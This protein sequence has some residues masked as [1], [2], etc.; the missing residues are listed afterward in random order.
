MTRITPVVLSG[1]A[2]TR[3]WPLSREQFPKQLL[4]LASVRSMI[5]DTVLR[6]TDTVRFGS[7]IVVTNEETRF[8]VAEQLREIGFEQ[9]SV[10][11]EPV[12]RNTAPAVAAAALLALEADPNAIILV[13]PS[14]HVLANLPAFLALVDKTAAAARDGYLVTFSIV[15][16]RP[17]TGYGYIR[18]GAA[19]NSHPD[20]HAVAAF[21]EKPDAERAA[22]FLAEG[23]YFWNSGMFLFSAAIFIDELG[24]HAPEVLQAVRAAVTGKTVDHDFVRLEAEAFKTCPGIS[25]DYA[26]MEKTARAAT[27]ACDV[28][29]TDVG[30]WSELWRIADKDQCG[31]ALLGDDVVV[32][33]SRN[34]YVRSEGMLTAVVGV[35]DLVVVVTDDAVLVTHRDRTQDVKLIV[36]RLRREGRS[37]LTT[38][39]R[40]YRPWGYYQTI[41]SGDR[42]QVKR[43]TIKPGAKLSLQKHYN[44]AEHLGGGERHRPGHPR[45]QDAD[46]ARE[47][48]GLYSHRHPAPPGEPRQGAAQPDRGAIRF[49]SRRGRHRPHRGYLRT[50][51]IAFGSQNRRELNKGRG[52][53]T[54]LFHPSI[55]REYDIRGIV[56]ETLSTADAEAIGRAFGGLVI[57]QGGKL[58]C[59]GYD[60]RLSSPELEGSLVAGLL[61]TGLTVHRVGR[62]PTPMLYYATH[63]MQ[64]DGGIMVT[65][66]HNPPD[67][68]GFKMVLHGKPFFAEQIQELGRLA[69][70]GAGAGRSGGGAVDTP[71]MD[72][73]VRRLAADYHGRR[74]LTVVW[75]AGNGA[76]GEVM[77]R[78][79][80]VLPGTHLL[81]NAE[82]DGTFPAHHPDPTEPENLVQLIDAVVQHRADLGI[83]FDGDGDR[84]GVVDPKGRV[85]WGDQMMMLL[86]EE[87]LAAQP[88][89]MVLADV[90]AS[91]ALFDHI[92]A[93][94]GR[95]V[96]CRTG[97]SLIKTRMA[98]TGAPLAGEMSGHLFFADRYY[99]FDDALYAAVRFISLVANWPD[100]DLAERYDRLP[101]LHNTPELR[102]PCADDRK[103]AV[104]AEV[105][106]RL[107]AAGAEVCAVDGVRVGTA[108]G[109]WLLRAS[110]TQAVLVARCESG[111][112]DGLQRLRR[113]LS[114]QLAASGLDY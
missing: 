62:G 50:H 51:L 23:G 52:P 101:R 46:R 96:M 82:I 65:G 28:G 15:P 1:G 6:F 80:D 66:S 16:G 29:W 43:L 20:L 84:I 58:V 109:W 76:T 100:T 38:H 21:V 89:A 77:S 104:V 55:L 67:H 87:V 95:P 94:G 39:E 3:L 60:G 31:N 69:A 86:A 32:E 37:E 61:S 81:L 91:Q 102:I 5:Q 53:M 25:V 93:L 108:D 47:R 30:A 48:V 106:T 18:R 71:V 99:G 11:L 36:D 114:E 79:A 14:D 73:Y 90:K 22:A 59:V 27:I 35:E 19:L 111:T 44:R 83:A 113:I 24:R 68:N 8:T 105:K 34:C 110:N 41:H 98:E 57:G 56:G 10:V 13:V 63:V 72:D 54:H 74:P 42:F 78:L 7:P 70:R 17:E 4:P 26:V 92:A 45:Q 85:L 49:L 112:P 88:G 2:G 40:V 12:A 107:A 75:D 103:F 64:A 33:A 97:H 9:I